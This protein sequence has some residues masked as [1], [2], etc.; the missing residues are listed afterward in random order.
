MGV[1]EWVKVGGSR[2]EG[3]SDEGRGADMGRW[4]IRKGEGRG[5][6]K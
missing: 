1:K 2:G 4:W 5:V 6:V 3:K